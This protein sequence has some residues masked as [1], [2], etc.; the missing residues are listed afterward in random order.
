MT[1]PI[2]HTDQVF[3]F[4]HADGPALPLYELAYDENN[5]GWQATKA[6]FPLFFLRAHY[7][8]DG[9]LDEFVRQIHDDTNRRVLIAVT[10]TGYRAVL[11]G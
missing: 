3:Q 10:D 9:A 8:A 7:G 5:E 4:A 2:T 1:T 6:G 11:E